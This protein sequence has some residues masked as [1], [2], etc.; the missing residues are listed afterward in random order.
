MLLAHALVVRHLGQ[1]WRWQPGC[2]DPVYWRILRLFQD[3]KACVFSI[4]QIAA[5]GQAEGIQ[6]GQWFGPNTISQVLK[7]VAVYDTWSN[8]C[9]HVALDGLVVTAEIRQLCHSYTRS[10]AVEMEGVTQLSDKASG[11]SENE[12]E[13]K[14]LLLLVPLRL[15][16]SEVNEVYFQALKQVFTSPHS[17][18][19]LGGKPNHA[20]WFIGHVEDELIYLDPHTTQVH[21]DLD[22]EVSEVS[23]LSYHCAVPASRMSFSKLDPS[24]ALGFFCKTEIEFEQFCEFF[25][26]QDTSISALFEVKTDMENLE[27]L[28]LVDGCP[29]SLPYVDSEIQPEGSDS[30]AGEDLW[31]NEEDFEFV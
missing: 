4:Q 14:P 9:V 22:L 13:W 6:V 31:N 28:V 29:D 16:L 1:G 2:D 15:G 19:I 26:K 8:L 30:L 25:T 23:D 21:T 20:Y 3:K 7:R 17:V 10:A 18:G 11:E 27:N 12:A 5:M 24:M